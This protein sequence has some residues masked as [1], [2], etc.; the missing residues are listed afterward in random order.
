MAIGHDTMPALS[1]NHRPPPLPREVTCD[2][3]GV[4]YRNPP[5][6]VIAKKKS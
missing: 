1:N 5:G 2:L 4:K 6:G 3:F